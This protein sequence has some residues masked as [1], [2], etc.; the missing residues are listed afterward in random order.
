MAYEETTTRADHLQWCKERALEYLK[1]NDVTGAITSLMSDLTKH[2]DTAR[3][4][5]IMAMMAMME[6]IKPFYESSK[7]SI[8]G[9]N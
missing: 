4:E 7:R 8:E 5:Q 1:T 9:F 6:F 2:S 3:L